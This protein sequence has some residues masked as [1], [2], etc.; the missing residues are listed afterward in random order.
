MLQ[1]GKALWHGKDTA[2]GSPLSPW[3]A[4]KHFVKK[5]KGTLLPGMRDEQVA[6]KS[7]RI[8]EQSPAH[9]AGIQSQRLDVVVGQIVH[10]GANS[11][12]LWIEGIGPLVI[13]DRLD[14]W[15]DHS[16]LDGLADFLAKEA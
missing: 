4:S 14:N 8:S 1:T 9:P 10:V 15:H 12:I 5:L 11:I 2:P 7:L 16:M 3:P 6:W 13:E